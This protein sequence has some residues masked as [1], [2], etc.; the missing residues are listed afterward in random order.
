M[1]LFTT[2]ALICCLHLKLEWNTCVFEVL[3]ILTV[4]LSGAVFVSV[5]NDYTDLQVDIIAGKENRLSSFHPKYAKLIL[6]FFGILGLGV[7][8]ICFYN[9]TVSI[10]ITL[11]SYLSYYFYSCNPFRFKSKGI[12]GVFADACGAHLFPC[13]LVMYQLGIFNNF[14]DYY[15]VISMFFWSFIVGLRGILYHQ[16]IDLE[17]D[18]KCGLNTVAVKLPLT[19][20][21]KIEPLL[22]SLEIIFWLYITFK[23]TTTISFI[24]LG[25]YVVVVFLNSKFL[26]YR[27][28]LI[29]SDLKHRHKILFLDLYNF[30][31]PFISFLY[32]SMLN[33]NV[34]LSC[35]LF[36]ILFG[37]ESLHNFKLVLYKLKIKFRY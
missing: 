31:Y 24:S 25:I 15:F 16:Y 14:V 23:N 18:L 13:I 1:G 35:V 3:K 28:T 7:L 22:V 6:I 21:K 34:I 11:G 10:L 37:Y 29:L 5:L 27:Y 9:S 32:L 17:N 4:L 30:Y 20:I 2:I 19:S 33:P 12:L 36:F 26:R 8:L